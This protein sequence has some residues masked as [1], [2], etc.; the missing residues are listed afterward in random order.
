[1]DAKVTELGAA[2]KITKDFS[3]NVKWDDPMLDFRKRASAG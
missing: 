1:M 3:G 2:S